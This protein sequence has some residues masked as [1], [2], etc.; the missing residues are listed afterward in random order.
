MRGFWSRASPK[1]RHAFA[2]LAGVLAGPALLLTIV[3][4]AASVALSHSGPSTTDPTVLWLGVAAPLALFALAYLLTDL[5]TWSLHHF[6]RRRL[7][8][9]FALKRVRAPADGRAAAVE[10]D[11]ERLVPLSESGVWPGPGGKA[12]PTLLVCA[13]AN[14]SDPGA[15]PPGRG[16]TSFTFSPAAI[17]GPLVG[18]IATDA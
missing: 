15:T 8:S 14:V 3:V 1:L 4:L 17:G 13:A 12:W 7:C 16:V 11:Y 10:R 5:T 9:A 2:Y 6:Y 18:A